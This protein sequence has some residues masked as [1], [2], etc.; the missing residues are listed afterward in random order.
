MANLLEELILEGG[1]PGAYK[2]TAYD[3]TILDKNS[4]SLSDLL[5]NNPQMQEIME[6]VTGYGGTIGKASKAVHPVI[7]K[8]LDKNAKA[9]ENLKGLSRPTSGIKNLSVDK[10][11]PTKIKGMKKEDIDM[12][13]R[14]VRPTSGIKNLSVDNQT[15]RKEIKR[16]GLNAVGIPLS[17]IALN[18]LKNLPGQ[19]AEMILPDPVDQYPPEANIPDM[20]DFFEMLEQRE[21]LKN[22]IEI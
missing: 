12:I 2:Q 6:M 15:A 21:K 5:I 14:A 22:S 9:I 8:I 20:I 10:K 1:Q 3:D 16:A 11:F 7:Q 13:A 4:L 19:L 17:V 18:K